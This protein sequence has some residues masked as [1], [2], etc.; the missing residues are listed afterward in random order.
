MSENL[1]TDR[2]EKTRILKMKSLLTFRVITAV[3]ISDERDQGKICHFS[4][5]NISRNHTI[6]RKDFDRQKFQIFVEVKN[7]SILII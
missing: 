1:E 2:H 5:S 3:F 6:H 7:V 4:N